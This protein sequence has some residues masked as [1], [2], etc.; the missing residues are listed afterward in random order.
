MIAY[1]PIAPLALGRPGLMPALTAMVLTAFF[2][3]TWHG[4]KDRPA[5]PENVACT[6][7]IA[8]PGPAERN[9]S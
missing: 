8:T 7:D 2:G 4:W 6:A 1:R 5:A 9:R 3:T